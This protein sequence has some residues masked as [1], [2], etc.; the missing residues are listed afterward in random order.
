M[1]K[2][3]R[4]PPKFTVENLIGEGD[5]VVAQGLIT[6]KEE[7]KETE[8]AYCDVWTVRDGKLA[9]LKAFVIKP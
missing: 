7:G 4:E 6:L 9:G 8:Y 3:Y 5:L 2:A 1:A